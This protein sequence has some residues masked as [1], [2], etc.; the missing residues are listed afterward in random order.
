MEI[1][2]MTDEEI[3]A[4]IGETDLSA[5]EAIIASSTADECGEA[6]S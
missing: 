6:T 4:K 5:L 1:I 3:A 2:Q